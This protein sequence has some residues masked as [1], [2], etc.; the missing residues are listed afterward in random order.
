MDGEEWRDRL[1]LFPGIC[2]HRRVG[3]EARGVVFLLSSSRHRCAC[4]AGSPLTPCTSWT[5]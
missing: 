4:H 5:D 2:V 3:S 1:A